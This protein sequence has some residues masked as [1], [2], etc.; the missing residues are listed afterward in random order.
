M[1]FDTQLMLM[2]HFCHH[3]SLVVLSS[4]SMQLCMSINVP[5][6]LEKCCSSSSLPKTSCECMFLKKSSFLLQVEWRLTIS[7]KIDKNLDNVMHYYDKMF[8][9]YYYCNYLE[10]KGHRKSLLSYRALLY[11][12]QKSQ[13]FKISPL[14]VAK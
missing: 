9:K 6:F 1:F 10:K 3:N 4:T 7:H 13:S 8:H 14:K 2:S 11:L 5:S 12:N